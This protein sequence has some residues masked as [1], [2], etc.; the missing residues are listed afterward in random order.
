MDERWWMLLAFTAGMVAMLIEL[1]LPGVVMGILGFLVCCGCIAYAYA[2]RHPVAGTIMLG[3][4][5]VFIPVFFLIWKHVLGKA[6]A[7]KETEKGFLASVTQE[8]DL[9][10]KQGQ[11]ASP[12]RPSGTALIDG[13]RYG[14]ITRGEMLDK[15]TPLKVIEVSGNRIIVKKG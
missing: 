8:E 6:L 5:I 14:V 10:G 9:L 11:A 2:N 4:L 12:L 15:G 3:A 1:A 7:I 13:K